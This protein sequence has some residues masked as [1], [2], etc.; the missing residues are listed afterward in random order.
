MR[1]DFTETEYSVCENDGSITVCVELLEGASAASIPVSLE[2]VPGTATS[3]LHL[4]L[5]PIVVLCM[6]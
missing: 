1:I 6:N 5:K 4:L 3:K 2:T